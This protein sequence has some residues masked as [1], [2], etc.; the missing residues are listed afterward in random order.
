MADIIDAATFKA[1]QETAG[2][3]IA[4]STSSILVPL[5]GVG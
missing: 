1:L 3:V 2:A 4:G 5:R